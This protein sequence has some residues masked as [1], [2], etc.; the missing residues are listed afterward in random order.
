MRRTKLG[1]SEP[2]PKQNML[3]RCCE[4]NEEVDEAARKRTACEP[5]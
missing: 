3:W 1:I 4:L 2:P 5:V